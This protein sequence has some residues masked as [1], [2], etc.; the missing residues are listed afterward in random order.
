MMAAVGLYDRNEPWI[1]SQIMPCLHWH[2]CM[3]WF[4]WGSLIFTKFWGD[5]DLWFV[6]LLI[7]SLLLIYWLHTLHIFIFSALEYSLSSPVQWFWLG[8]KL[9]IYYFKKLLFFLNVAVK[10]VLFHCCKLKLIAMEPNH[11]FSS[12][13]GRWSSSSP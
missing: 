6:S 12:I 9:L 13:C 3:L 2:S 4:H 5:N 7:R 1:K 10:K 11:T 8:L